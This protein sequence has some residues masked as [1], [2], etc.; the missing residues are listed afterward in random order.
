VNAT[1]CVCDSS[2]NNHCHAHDAAGRDD[3]RGQGATIQLEDAKTTR[4]PNRNAQ[5]PRINDKTPGKSAV[6]MN[7]R[8][9][10][11][12]QRPAELKAQLHGSDCRRQ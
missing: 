6:A 10:A 4:P 1:Q 11:D 9:E 8:N 2:G 5:A 12:D 7:R 3:P